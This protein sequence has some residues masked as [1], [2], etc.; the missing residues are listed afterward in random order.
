MSNRDPPESP[1]RCSEAPGDRGAHGG[2]RVTG[3]PCF[4]E[5]T[6]L[7]HGWVLALCLCQALFGALP[8]TPPTGD[9][10]AQTSPRKQS[11]TGS[12]SRR[13]TAGTSF[14]WPFWASVDIPVDIPEKDSASWSTAPSPDPGAGIVWEKDPSPRADLPSNTDLNETQVRQSP[15][16]APQPSHYL[17]GKDSP[18]P[19][20]ITLMPAAVPFT[21]GLNRN[22]AALLPRTRDPQRTEPPSPRP[23][24][25]PAPPV[26]VTHT[27]RHK[28]SA[29][30]GGG[31]P[32]RGGTGTPGELSKTGISAEGE[33]AVERHKGISETGIST[34]GER[35]LNATIASNGEVLEEV[36]QKPTKTWMVSTEPPG[37]MWS[38]VGRGGLA[39]HVEEEPSRSGAVT[40]SSVITTDS[41][42]P[43]VVLDEDSP[44]LPDCNVDT[45]GACSTNDV[46]S[47]T[48]PEDSTTPNQSHGPSPPL[49]VLLDTDWNGAMATWG[50]A[51][52]AHVYGMG[53]LFAMVAL[54]STLGLLGVPFLRPPGWGYLALAHVFLIMAGSSRAFSLFYDAYGH[55]D[56]LPAASSAL[57]HQ[58]PFPCFTAAFATV[59]LL[60][61]LRSRTPLP[62]SPCTCS[63]AA[64]MFLH[65]GA[66][67]GPVL[68]LQA[69]PQL[70]CLLLVP[71]G[72]F[73]A[74][75]AF[76]SIA[77]LIFCCYVRA[78]AKHVYHL[79]P[80]PAPGGGPRQIRHPFADPPGSWD[81]AAVTVAFSAVFA[82][83][84]AG[85]QLYAV[86]HA[87]GLAP[88]AALAPWPWWA[89][90]LSCRTLCGCGCRGN[91]SAKPPAMPGDHE[92]EKLEMCEGVGSERLPL[93][94]LMDPCLSSLDGLDLL[95]HG[96]RVLAHSDSD[97]G[98]DP[99]LTVK[100]GSSCTSLR[101][102]S[103]STADLRPPSPINL[104]RSID[105]ALFSDALFPHGLFS[106]A[107]RPA[108]RPNRRRS[109]GSLSLCGRSGPEGPPLTESL[110][111]RGLYRT[112]SCQDMEAGPSPIGSSLSGYASADTGPTHGVEP[113][114]G[115]NSSSSSLG[116]RSLEGFSQV[117]CS[118][119]E[120]RGHCLITPGNLPQ[121]SVN[122]GAQ[123][124]GLYQALDPASQESLDRTAEMD[125]AV[126][127][128]FINVCRQIDALSV[129]SD[130][131]DL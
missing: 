84:C 8:A 69:F 131:I 102:D 16:P 61:S 125:L 24:G 108:Q 66:T 21:T 29:G 78:D 123:F 19:S 1:K 126:Q 89:F 83:A 109:S 95:Y 6:M 94:A 72:S 81:R 59:F 22:A 77:Y 46:W 3:R 38:T 71:Q 54:L 13:R 2:V 17:R 130:T 80:N 98:S 48:F 88:P 105:E 85:L 124:H 106:P 104:R 18:S 99:M 7:T 51:W 91:T 120:G 34:V 27:D 117:L 103:D 49:L 86:L 65:F 119:P 73:A 96:G 121:S 43:D 128:E 60:L 47:P 114:R 111:D 45:S 40:V 52:E 107:P 55:Q 35:E 9:G 32:A 33:S 112:S 44:S 129:C 11:T 70:P 82:L 110:T 26:S 14:F 63:L 15:T 116:R 57:V 30:S 76:L 67:F 115:S 68:L 62:R 53:S 39:S 37:P 64:L 56:R 28:L 100:G 4:N 58:A 42:L 23:N 50:M 87:R 101:L 31:R 74:L 10:P 93:Y 79:N 113:R 118:A 90:Q 75:T 25:S 92:W 20:P 36:A 5:A 12:N 127:E 122:Q 97:P 41:L